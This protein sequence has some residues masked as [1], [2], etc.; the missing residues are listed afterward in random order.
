MISS[1]ACCIASW[2]MSAGA[3]ASSVGLAGSCPGPLSS[4]IHDL[5]APGLPIMAWLTPGVLVGV[6]PYSLTLRA[7]SSVS[8]TQRAESTTR[9]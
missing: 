1:M 7:D 8:R 2:A 5:L 9:A 6:R 4:W 3:P